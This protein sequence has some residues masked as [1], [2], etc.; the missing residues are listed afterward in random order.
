VVEV[1]GMAGP[2]I[3]VDPVEEVEDPS[4]VEQEQPTRVLPEELEVVLLLEVVEVEPARPVKMEVIQ[5]THVPEV[6]DLSFLYLPLLPD[7]LEDGSVVVVEVLPDLQVPEALG[8]QEVEEMVEATDL[9]YRLHQ[10][11][12]IPVVVEAVVTTVSS[13]ETED[14]V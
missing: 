10:D 3:Q 7:L 8:D 5:Q 12:Q 1:V 4:Q 9:V 2:E 11:H 6:Q 14:Q 13:E